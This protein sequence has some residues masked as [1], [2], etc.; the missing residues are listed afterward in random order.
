MSKT[1]DTHVDLMYPSK[2]IKCVDLGGKDR[3]LTIDHINYGEELL[4]EGGHKKSKHIMYF[5]GAKKAFVL[6]VTNARLISEALDEPDSL[7]WPGRR[8][9]LYPT[10]AKFKG[11]MVPAVRVRDTA[12]KQDKPKRERE[13]GED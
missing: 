3:D 12:P 7:N 2:Y 11:K 5:K 9:T 10:K 4:C 6:N 1:P 13:T 8:I